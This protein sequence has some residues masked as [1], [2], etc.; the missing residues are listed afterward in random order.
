M[1]RA[2]SIRRNASAPS[3][4]NFMAASNP[5]ET[6]LRASKPRHAIH[7]VVANQCK[8][9]PAVETPRPT[10]DLRA[11]TDDQVPRRPLFPA[12]ADAVALASYGGVEC[13]RYG[14]IRV[15][16]DNVDLVAR[17]RPRRELRGPYPSLPS[18]P[19]V[20]RSSTTHTPGADHAARSTAWR[21]SQLSTFPSRLTVPS[22]RMSMRILLASTSE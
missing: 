9:A 11:G 15:A 4:A 12:G 13:D 17:I 6:Y 7:R 22:P 8:L 18:Q 19:I 20:R 2:D 1:S 10:V 5:K 21:S 16:P 14:A 3:A